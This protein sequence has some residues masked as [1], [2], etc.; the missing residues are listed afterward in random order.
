MPRP[1]SLWPALGVLAAAAA[2]ARANPH[3]EIASAADE[4]DPFDVHV[5][6]DY[7]FTSVRAAIKREFAGY[8]GTDPDGPMPLV[9]DLVL[10]GLRHEIVPRLEIGLFTD[11]AAYGALPI[12][13]RDQRSLDLDQREDVCVFPGGGTPTCIDST[14]SS[15]IQD[16]LLPSTGF[17]AGDPGGPGFADGGDPMI[18][19][20]VD[21]TGLD[22]L[23]LGLAWAP[24][25]QRRDDTKP[26]WKIGAEARIA[27]GKPAA[28]DR[29]SPSTEDGVG[30]GVHEVKLWTSMAKRTSWAI[31]YFE[32]WWIAAIGK[33]DDSA[34]RDPP[35]GEFGAERLDP[36]QQA[37]TRFGFEALTWRGDTPDEH[38]GFD[39][40]TR[41][42]TRFAGRAYS[43]MWEVLAFAGDAAA[44][45]PLVLEADPRM[46]G[47]EF[48]HPGISNVE[49]YLTMAARLGLEAAIGPRVQFGASVEYA[50]DQ[51]H[52][53]TFAD[54]GVDDPDDAN[55]VVDP[56]T[57]EVNPFHVP[58]IDDAGH[59][60]RVDQARS[61][62]VGV[63]AL[64]LF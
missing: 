27:I 29:A 30:R 52:L 19:R 31:P 54:A 40:S 24:M 22:Q 51:S 17:D 12:V 3:L 60:Y 42:E 44:G 7:V 32:A 21:R 47:P 35:Q 43:E 4:G 15:T 26:T 10:S 20:G 58:T 63:H 11:L 39:V 41:L 45:G 8:P 14:N 6:V 5:G 2:P 50:W 13:V 33:T 28:F 59:R 34:F 55:D 62:V 53:I 9:K 64:V 57:A 18:F 38:V 25:N 46:G 48:S 16:G 36:Q 56:G 49:N 23:Q 1:S 61:F 37:G